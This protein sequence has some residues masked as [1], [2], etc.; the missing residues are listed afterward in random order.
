MTASGVSDAAGASPIGA[1]LAVRQSPP[2]ALRTLSTYA[3]PN[4][5]T[6]NI[7]SHV[8]GD[9][10]L[11]GT[12]IDGARHRRKRARRR[13]RGGRQPESRRPRFSERG[14]TPA[15]APWPD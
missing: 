5:S 4:I 14:G 8:A 15:G 11:T 12:N 3:I 9:P 7:E 2:A 1:R 13:I 10:H 6:A